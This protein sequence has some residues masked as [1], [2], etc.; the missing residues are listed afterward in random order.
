MKFFKDAIQKG[1]K[2]L[3]KHQ[4]KKMA[5]EKLNLSGEHDDKIDELTDKAID[6]I[7][8]DNIIKA[9]KIFDTLKS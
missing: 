5:N 7:G 2:E 9:K 3:I 8:A 6:K 4:V 1:K